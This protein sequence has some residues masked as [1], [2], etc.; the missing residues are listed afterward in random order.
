MKINLPQD[1]NHQERAGTSPWHHE[2]VL[3]PASDTRP[4]RVFLDTN[5]GN[6]SAVD[7]RSGALVHL[8]CVPDGIASLEGVRDALVDVTD[9]LRVVLDGHTREWIHGNLSWCLEEDAQ[10]ALERITAKLDEAIAAAPR[11]TPAAVAL[12]HLTER[13]GELGPDLV[14]L[15]DAAVSAAEDEGVFVD[16]TAALD[17]LSDAWSEAQ[18]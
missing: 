13:L 5:F 2:L 17:W 16:A 3:A 8:A 12:A 10:A 15:A 6:G 18:G 1:T 9:D 4:D 7:V 11:Y 14:A